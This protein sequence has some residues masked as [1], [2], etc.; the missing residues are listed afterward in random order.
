MLDGRLNAKIKMPFLQGGER[1][2][3]LC[4]SGQS[5]FSL[6]AADGRS[7][8]DAPE[9]LCGLAKHS[10]ASDGG[11]PP[12]TPPETPCG[13]RCAAAKPR[14]TP[15]NPPRARPPRR[16]VFAFGLLLYELF[17]R[18]P[19]FGGAAQGPEQLER[20]LAGIMD[21]DQDLRPGRALS[22]RTTDLQQQS[23]GSRR[24]P[25]GSESSGLFSG[26]MAELA[27]ACWQRVP[28]A[29][30]AGFVTVQSAFKEAC[31]EAAA[32]RPGP[33]PPPAVQSVRRLRM[34]SVGARGGFTSDEV[35]RSLVPPAVASALKAGKK[36]EPEYF[37]A[38]T[39]VF[40]DVVGFTQ[41]SEQIGE[42][43]VSNMLDRLFELFD[44]AAARHGLFK[45][46]TIG[47]AARA[48]SL[49]SPW[50]PTTRTVSRQGG[51]RRGS[52]PVVSG[53]CGKPAPLL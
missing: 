48:R 13:L 18:S 39:M 3:K 31:D 52:V 7:P 22:R 43:A 20:T 19:A 47:D 4:P 37:P 9:V 5:S 28:S 36:H 41:L 27:K 16:T 1:V 26:P 32:A 8:W 45:V 14:P 10:E 51:V 11:R 6:S 46:D 40:S 49:G 38:V 25:R 44:S 21:P 23:A 24:G 35:L 42:L 12:S 53:H 50:G 34:Q 15:N 33:G 2:P 30:P 17:A 29:R